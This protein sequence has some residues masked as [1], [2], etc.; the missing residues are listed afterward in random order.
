MNADNAY[1]SGSQL[2][3]VVQVDGEKCVNCHTCISVCP[4]K[5]CNDGSGDFVNVD[6]NRC[7][8]CGRCLEVCSH[9]ARTLR[10]ESSEFLQASEN[11]EP[12]VAIVAPSAV[13]NFPDQHLQ[14]NAW[15]KSLGVAAVFDVSFGAEL[16]AKSLAEHL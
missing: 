9:N 16:T 4:V 3:P 2:S 5:I 13:A 11:A 12:M 15:L 8:G 7:I 6:P 1:R 10:D 14:L